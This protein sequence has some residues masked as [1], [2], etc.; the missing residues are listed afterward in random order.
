MIQ[1]YQVTL[2]HRHL[3]VELPEGRALI[4]TGAPFSA[5]R[6]GRLTWREESHGVHRGGYMG[7]NFDW[8]SAKIGVQVDALLGMDLLAQTTLFFDVHHGRLT[9]GGEIPPGFTP[10]QYEV[11][12]TSDL[13]VLPILI[14]GLPARA[15]WDTGAQ[16]G[17][18]TNWKYLR[19]GEPAEGFVDFSP[20]FGDIEV[21]S[22]HVARIVID[23]H[24]LTE[25]FGLA[26]DIRSGGMSPVPMKAFLEALDLE[27]IIGPSWMPRVK[28]WLN[29][30]DRTYA[31]GV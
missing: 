18:V 29:P 26:P 9:V 19:H 16:L 15:A 1:H 22:S 20:M 21:P 10:R 30:L 27:A 31:L 5:S 23:G 2:L 14:G 24:H 25:R 28:V 17:Y 8:L 6:T 4:D 13:P 7:F 11:L 12:P 3:F